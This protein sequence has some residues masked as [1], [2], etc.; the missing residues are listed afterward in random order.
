MTYNGAICPTCKKAI[1][2]PGACF[3]CNLARRSMSMSEPPRLRHR[4]EPS[5]QER[6]EILGRL[7]QERQELL[8][9]LLETKKY[10]RSKAQLKV[11]AS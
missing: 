3:L 11:R 4:R 2:M 6:S 5:D 7:F 8:G 10:S 9:R 1:S